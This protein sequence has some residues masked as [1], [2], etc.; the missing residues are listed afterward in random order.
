MTDILVIGASYTAIQEAK[1]LT[2]VPRKAK[3]IGSEYTASG[4][5]NPTVYIVRYN[6]D[7]LPMGS[8]SNHKKINRIMEQLRTANATYYS[9]TLP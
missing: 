7:K 3:Y 9:V 6:N 4:Y 8:I 5:D 1:K 2:L